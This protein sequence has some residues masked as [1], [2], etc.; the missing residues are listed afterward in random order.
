[1]I[2]QRKEY[3]DRLISLKDKKIIKIITGVRRRGRRQIPVC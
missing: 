3:L 2:I 1:M